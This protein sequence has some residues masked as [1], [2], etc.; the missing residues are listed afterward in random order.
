LLGS[1]E[2]LWK[3]VEVCCLVYASLWRGKEH[4]KKGAQSVS[5]WRSVGGSTLGGVACA[6]YSAASLVVRV[7][8]AVVFR[9]WLLVVLAMPLQV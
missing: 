5:P 3:L 9:W 6:T 7:V 8:R 4:S 1:L 2:A